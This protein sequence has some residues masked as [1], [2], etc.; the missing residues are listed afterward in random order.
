M[1]RDRPERRRELEEAEDAHRSTRD[2]SS[3]ST[4]AGFVPF[5]WP[6]L[7][8]RGPDDAAIPE[9]RYDKRLGE[10]YDDNYDR[11]RARGRERRATRDDAWTDGGLIA[12]SMVAGVALIL[13]PEPVTS[14]VGLALVGAGAVAWLVDRAT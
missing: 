9:G 5:G 4:G 6:T 10:S 11:E 12:L 7:P 14:V 2:A 1:S 3:Q 13:V 8:S